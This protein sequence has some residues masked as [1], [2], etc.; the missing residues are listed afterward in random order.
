MII[1]TASFTTSGTQI[2]TGR[3]ARIP[4]ERTAFH[5]RLFQRRW[6]P[7]VDWAIGDE[8][9]HCPMVDC[10]AAAQLAQAVN[11]GKR[12]LDTPPGGSFLINEYGQILVPRPT[13]QHRVVMVGEWKGPLQFW[14]EPDAETFDL[15]CDNLFEAGDAWGLPYLGIPHHLSIR[16]EIYFWSEDTHGGAKVL[17]PMPNDELID[18]LRA[19]RPSGAVRFIVT[20]PGHVLTKVPI[21]HGRVETWEA[22]YIGRLDYQRWYPKED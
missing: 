16:N 21:R 3:C 11:R 19:E 15:A 20:Y 1:E 10:P 17:P 8:I 9:H 4:G 22:R 2:W 13:G 7:F 18:A 6:W 14:D 12:A 5:V